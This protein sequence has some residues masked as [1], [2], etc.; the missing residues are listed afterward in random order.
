MA[1]TASIR[2]MGDEN[3]LTYE[4]LPL[5][6]FSTTLGSTNK[7]SSTGTTI[8]AY[9]LNRNGFEFNFFF[10]ILSYIRTYN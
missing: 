6:V 7:L 5:E 4:Y 2:G 1:K 10:F 8:D 3:D 9:S